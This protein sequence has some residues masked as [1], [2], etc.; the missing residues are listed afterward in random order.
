MGAS[1]WL[2]Y[3]FLHN[4]TIALQFLQRMQTLKMKISYSFIL[5]GYGAPQYNITQLTFQTVFVQVHTNQ[6][7]ATQ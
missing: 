3:I 5:F 2:P 6:S 1:S 7:P 4:Q